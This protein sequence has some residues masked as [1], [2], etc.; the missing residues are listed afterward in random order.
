MNWALKPTGDFVTLMKFGVA[1][2]GA[3]KSCGNTAAAL[4]TAAHQRRQHLYDDGSL[5]ALAVRLDEACCPHVSGH[6]VSPDGVI[7]PARRKFEKVFM[8]RG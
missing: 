2:G 7:A 8:A 1:A 4:D 3:V 6:E 5:A